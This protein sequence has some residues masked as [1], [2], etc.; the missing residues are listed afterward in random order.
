MLKAFK[1][2][3]KSRQS[4]AN[5]KVYNKVKGENPFQPR[6]QGKDQGQGKNDN[7]RQKTGENKR[8]LF[9]RDAC[10]GCSERGHQKKDSPLCGQGA[11]NIGQGNF[12]KTD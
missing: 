4:Q 9:Y 8:L 10:F 3:K 6:D 12:Q 7:K 11:G 5:E 1:T 2:R